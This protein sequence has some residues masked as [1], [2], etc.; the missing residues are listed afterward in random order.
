LINKDISLSL[1]PPSVGPGTRSQSAVCILPTFDNTTHEQTASLITLSEAVTLSG[2]DAKE[3]NINEKQLL[4]E[5]VNNFVDASVDITDS[6][7]IAEATLSHPDSKGTLAEA[8]EAN[9]KSQG[10]EDDLDHNYHELTVCN[11]QV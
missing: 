9:I 10:V 4:V 11:N 5:Q 6:V 8:D 7:V 3:N 1:I 2:V